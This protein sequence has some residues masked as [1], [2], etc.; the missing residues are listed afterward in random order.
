ME[1]VYNPIEI[2]RLG[3]KKWEEK[4]LFKPKNRSTRPNF[5]I[6]FPLFF[7]PKKTR[8]DNIISPILS[9]IILRRKFMQK[10]NIEVLPII[11]PVP[12]ETIKIIRILGLA[13]DTS[14]ADLSFRDKERRIISNLFAKLYR[15]EVI[16]V[17]KTSRSYNWFLKK[18]PPIEP[19]LGGR[20][21]SNINFVPKSYQNTFSNWIDNIQ[22][23]PIS[24]QRQGGVPI[25]AYYCVQCTNIMVPEQN[26]RTCEKCGSPQIEQES[27]VLEPWWF[28]V[29]SLF[30]F[31]NDEKKTYPTSLMVSS[32]DTLSPL[33][34]KMMFLANQIGKGSPFL[35]LLIPGITRVDKTLKG[36]GTRQSNGDPF[37]NI[38][39]YGSDV[40]RFTL[41]SL[42][43]PGLPMRI[44]ENHLIA[45]KTFGIKI[46]NASRF[47]LKNLKGD[48]TIDIKVDKVTDIDKWILNSLNNIT[49]K[50]N[51]Y[52]DK[53]DIDKAAFLIYKFFRNDYC[54]WYLEFSKKDLKNIYTKNVLKFTLFRLLQI[55]HPFMPFLTETIYQRLRVKRKGFLIKTDYPTFRS[56]LVFTKEF[57]RVEMLRRVIKETRRIKAENGIKN[58]RRIR[59]ILITDSEGEK[60]WLNRYLKYFNFL[61]HSHS[62]KVYLDSTN[63]PKGF[64]GVCQNWQILLPF[65]S[66]KQRL[67]ELAKLKEEMDIVEKKIVDLEEKIFDEYFLNSHLQSEVFHLKNRLQKNIDKKIKIRRT[68]DEL[69]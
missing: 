31:M 47:I 11:S 65:E 33:V 32:I 37:T 13:V 57:S 7:Q 60:N 5:S 52:L 30:L 43:A 51:D 42:A 34:F 48:E 8:M 27:I 4:K 24:H 62:T 40:L 39:K 29:L 3:S 59:T 16:Q 1:K 28:L 36:I 50:I 2:E 54:S 19:D 64:L 41:A 63:L 10:F 14:Q 44:S 56:D 68:I 49:V 66:D 23:L 53:Y 55:I 18:P 35:D 17:E 45:Y 12:L 58:N 67:D 25:P 26:P 46:W 22:K 6:F 38:K 20:L 9:D 61:A 15:E 21:E 69:S